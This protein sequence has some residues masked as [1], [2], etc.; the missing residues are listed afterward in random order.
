VGPT[1]TD[2]TAPVPTTHP[3]GFRFF[4][5]GEFAER[6]SYYGMR[7]ILALYM[8]EKLGVDKADAGTFMSLFIAACYFFPLVGG[9]VADNFLGKYWTIVLF[10]VPYVAAQFLVG[11]EDRYVVFGA[12]VLL[13][14]GSGVIKPNISTLMG[15]TYDQ[16]RPGQ[17]Q[18]LTSAWRA[19]PRRSANGS[20]TKTRRSRCGALRPPRS[21]RCAIR[22]AS[23][24]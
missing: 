17:E 19:L 6:C 4:F 12:L 9:Y 7:A 13:A 3:V 14:M 21:P 11:I 10:S 20:R 5:W 23:G 2:P 8:T 16:Q 18:L 1:D 22:T 24:P 15:M